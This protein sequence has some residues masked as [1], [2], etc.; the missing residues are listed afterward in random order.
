VIADRHDRDGA[1]LIAI[2]IPLVVLA[3]LLP[4]RIAST[5]LFEDTGQ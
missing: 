1:A 4:S 2:G 5:R 3:L